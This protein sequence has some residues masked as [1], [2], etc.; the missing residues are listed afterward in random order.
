MSPSLAD[1]E[2]PERPR[3]RARVLILGL[4]L[5]VTAV[6]LAACGSS[7]SSSS[8][9][10]ETSEASNG[11]GGGE[12]ESAAKGA[13]EP[14]S[15][16]EESVNI[17]FV[18]WGLSNSAAK[19]MMRGIEKKTGEMN[20]TAE[21]QDAALDPQKQLSIVEDDATS[22]NFQALILQPLDGAGIT[23]AVEEAGEAGLTIVSAFTPVGPDQQ[24]MKPQ[25]AGVAAVVGAPVSEAGTG[26]GEMAVEACG[27]GPCEVAYMNGP[28]DVPHEVLRLNAFE[29][30]LAKD[31]KAKLVAVQEGEPSVPEGLKLGQNL[32]TAHPDL[33]VLVGSGDQLAVGATQAAQESGSSVQIVGN[34]GSVQAIE[35]IQ[36][37]EMFG[38]YLALFETEGE[39]AAELA[40]EAARGNEVKETVNPAENFPAPMNATAKTVGSF[41]GQWS[42][43]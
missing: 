19:A 9:A 22:G 28:G 1:P 10:T 29:E 27:S 32:L 42:V 26:M 2:G 23:P 12:Q 40:I 37:G 17:A 8:G 15:G 13:G 5:L 34:G 20:A 4:L 43:E 33:D 41:K 3:G 11:G 18:G 6:S 14:E 25:V 36:K 39:L 31:P 30:A 7:G 24:A 21:E 16:S 35:K 38:S